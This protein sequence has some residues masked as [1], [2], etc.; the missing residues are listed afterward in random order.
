MATMM[1]G[2][3]M[4]TGKRLR[5]WGRILAVA[6]ILIAM[7]GH[8]SQAVDPQIEEKFKAFCAEWM[9]KLVVREVDNRAAIKW[10]NGPDGVKGEFV[11][12]GTE[13]VC[14]VKEPASKGATPVGT[15]KYRELRYRKV[16]ATKE[17]AAKGADT[18]IE[19]TEVTEI[20]RYTGGK[21]VY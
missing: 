17:E 19:A 15:I 13:N 16:G 2:N 3:A 11:G 7:T 5:V 9:K 6:A 12:Y 8:A 14:E 21:W 20:F 18:A 10:E 4:S 1:S